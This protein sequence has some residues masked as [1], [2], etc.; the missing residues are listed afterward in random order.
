MKS[1]FITSTV[2][3]NID[4]PVRILEYLSIFTRLKRWYLFFELRNCHSKNTL[5][6]SLSLIPF[7]NE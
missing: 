1:A 4:C 3:G 6:S 5:F 2:G 7:I